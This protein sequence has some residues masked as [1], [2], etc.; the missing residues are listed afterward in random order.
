[1]QNDILGMEVIDTT[2]HALDGMF[3]GPCE[4]II[5]T[6]DIVISSMGNNAG[7]FKDTITT[8]T[9]GDFS[10][11]LAAQKYTLEIINVY[12]TDPNI[13]GPMIVQYLIVGLL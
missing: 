1:M 7:C 6:A 13:L 3:R 2:R 5:G 9:N 8:D 4:A 12:P 11:V 10:I